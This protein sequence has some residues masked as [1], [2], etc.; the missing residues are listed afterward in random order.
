MILIALFLCFVSVFVSFVVLACLALFHLSLCFCAVALSW[1][2]HFYILWWSKPRWP[3]TSQVG[4]LI[5]PEC[6]AVSSRESSRL[7][8]LWFAAHCSYATYSCGNVE[9]L[10][11][12]SHTCLFTSLPSLASFPCQEVLVTKATWTFPLTWP[13]ICHSLWLLC[14]DVPLSLY[15]DLLNLSSKTVF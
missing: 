9:A 8:F 2:L 11:C 4:P 1:V 10:T 7:W 14:I 5:T 12:P 15:F 6:E 3:A 13:E